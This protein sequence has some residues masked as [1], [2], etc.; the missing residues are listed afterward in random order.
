MALITRVARLFRADLHAVLDRLEEPEALLRQALREMDEAQAQDEQRLKLFVQALG[1]AASHETDLHEVLAVAE[2]QLAAALDAGHDD[3]ARAVIRRRLEADQA[4]KAL[5]RRIAKL[6]ASQ[7]DMA[8]RVAGQRTRLESMRQ[9]VE[10]LAGQGA[11]A[12]DRDWWDDLDRQDCFVPDPRV[13]SAD[14]EL[15]LL[16]A[17]QGRPGSQPGGKQP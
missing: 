16:A 6:S 14:V 4:L 12:E 17:K 9:K 5:T 1:Q 3:L 7:A 8:T 11:I 2:V 10:V 15:A 13:Q